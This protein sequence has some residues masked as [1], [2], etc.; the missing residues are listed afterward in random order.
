MIWGCSE[1]WKGKSEGATSLHPEGKWTHTKERAG[2]S[3][4]VQGSGIASTVAATAAWVRSL[5]WEL[6]HAVGAAIKRK[7]EGRKEGGRKERKKGK[8]MNKKYFGNN[9]RK[10]SPIVQE[11]MGSEKGVESKSPAFAY[12]QRLHSSCMSHKARLARRIELYSRGYHN[13][14]NQLYFNKTLKK[15][16]W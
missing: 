13:I 7:K 16:S 8:Y 2:S 4:A 14:V 15:C 11:I 10:W 5:A 3:C 1:Q 12:E 6:P 9:N